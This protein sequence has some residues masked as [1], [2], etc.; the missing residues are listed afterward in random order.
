ME[1]LL[2]YE[3]YTTNILFLSYFFLLMSTSQ[4]GLQIMQDHSSIIELLAVDNKRTMLPLPTLGS[5]TIALNVVVI[6]KSEF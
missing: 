2:H 5:V 4:D 6:V 3:L 1:F